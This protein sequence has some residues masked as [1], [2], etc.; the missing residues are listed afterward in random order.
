MAE[1]LLDAEEWLRSARAGCSACGNAPPC[2]K[3]EVQLAD[4]LLL[5]IAVPLDPGS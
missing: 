1:D 4:E 2:V 5:L 3:A